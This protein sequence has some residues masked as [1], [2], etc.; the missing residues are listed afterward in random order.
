MLSVVTLNVHAQS[1]MT[2][3]TREVVRTRQVQPSGQLPH[4]QIMNLDVVL[5]LRDQAGLDA[6]LRELYDRSSPTYRQFLTPKQFTQKFGPTQ[7]DYDAVVRFA[8]ANGFEVV[9]GS[10]DGMDVQIRGPVSAVEGAFHVTMRTYPHPEEH[11]IFYAPD[12]E[13]TTDLPF[14]LWHVSGL[15]NYSIPH[16]T[17]SRRATSPR[18]TAL[19]RIKLFPMRPQGPVHRLRFWVATCVPPTTAEQL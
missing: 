2:R 11:R 16:P 13:P 3:H 6:F 7:A 19:M 9:G 14:P 12:S 17:W 18:P 15:D 4:N 10:R 5:P 1:M 8:K